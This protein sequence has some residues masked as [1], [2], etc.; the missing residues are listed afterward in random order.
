MKRYAWPGNVRELQ[1]AIRFAVV[2]SRGRTIRVEHLPAEL[3][4]IAPARGS[5]GPARK[6]D[7][8]GVR[9]ALERTGG[10][11]ARAARLLGVGRATLYRFLRD[12]PG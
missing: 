3:R 11:K 12:F 5:R 2:R 10:N 6:L 9:A 7:P 8:D 4:E 1:S